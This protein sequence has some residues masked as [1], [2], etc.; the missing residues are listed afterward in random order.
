MGWKIE[1]LDNFFSSDFAKS[2]QSTYTGG[3]YAIYGPNLDLIFFSSVTLEKGQ[4]FVVTASLQRRS[5]IKTGHT[6]LS[7]NKMK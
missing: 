6:D 1:L 5:S 4:I 2:F 7:L 3:I